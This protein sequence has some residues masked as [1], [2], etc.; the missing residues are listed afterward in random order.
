MLLNNRPVLKEVR[1]L[2]FVLESRSPPVIFHHYYCI[3]ASTLKNSVERNI[4][5]LLKLPCNNCCKWGILKNHASLYT[6]K[7]LLSDGGGAYLSF[8]S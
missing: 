2:K 7:A 6:V 4:A 5:N 1:F 3:Y 8:Q